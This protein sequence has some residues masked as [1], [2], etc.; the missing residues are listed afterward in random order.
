MK[1]D[2]YVELAKT[3]AEKSHHLNFKHGAVLLSGKK[4]ISN[5]YNKQLNS[6]NKNAFGYK[7]MHAEMNLIVNSKS[8]K[9][10]NLKKINNLVAVVVRVSSDG[11][12]RL[13]KPCDHCF[14]ILKQNN[15]KKV[16]YSTGKDDH[17]LDVINLN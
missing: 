16:Y 11:S 15:I 1:Y 7:S 4:I 10:T 5:G 2:Y 6:I 3:Q 14:N 8:Q 17:Y 9:N 12:F 13:S